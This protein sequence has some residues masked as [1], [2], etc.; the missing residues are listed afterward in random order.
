MLSLKSLKKMS[1]K[2]GLPPGTLVFDVDDKE[3]IVESTISLLDYNEENVSEKILNNIGEAGD[4]KASQTVS[5]INIT[6]I[7][8]VAVIEQVG[9]VFDIHNLVLEDIVNT[10]HRPKFEDFGDYIFVVLKMPEIDNNHKISGRQVSLLCGTNWVVSFCEQPSDV[11]DGVINRIKTG[12]WRIR[13]RGADYLTYALIDSVVD[14]NYRLLHS[15]GEDIEELEEELLDN[16]DNAT[17]AKIHGLR[18]QVMNI[19]R[20]C[21]SLREMLHG[22]IQSESEL[23]EERTYPFFRDVLDHIVQIIDT[24]ETYRD[25]LKGM[26][27]LYLSSSSNRM[28]EVMKVL[29]I[30]ASIFIPLTFI[31]G[32]YGMNFQFMPE[33]S[34]H[35]GY[36]GALIVMLAAGMGMLVYFRVKGWL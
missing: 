16:P 3:Q 20:I 33:L 26:L 19:Q 14:K 29:T 12:I 32:I 28:N 22:I 27:D 13:K 34:W 31:A 8:Q 15:I 21:W 23:I 2:Q 18:K 7:Q 35:Y 5:W 1:K 17:L 6:G 11:F 9:K 25:I 30:M 36:F 24:V 4:L 10:S